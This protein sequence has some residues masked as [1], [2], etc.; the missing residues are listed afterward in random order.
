M[1]C[2]RSLLHKCIFEVTLELNGGKP[3]LKITILAD[4]S[5]WKLEKNIKILPFNNLCYLILSRKLIKTIALLLLY[6]YSMGG[7]IGMVKTCF[8]LTSNT[9]ATTVFFSF[10]NLNAH[11]W[12][13]DCC[14]GSYTYMYILHYTHI[15]ARCWR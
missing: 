2:N 9:M 15:R 7:N 6:K 5:P 13:F 10:V 1:H 4:R 12:I 11:L 8:H 3:K 14:F